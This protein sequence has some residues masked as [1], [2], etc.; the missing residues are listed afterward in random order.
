M[1]SGTIIYVAGNAPEGWTEDDEAHIRSFESKADLIEIIT[2]ET[3]HFDI[4]DA[5]RDLI[6]RG[7][8]QIICKMAVFGESGG[9]EFTGKHL[10]L[11]G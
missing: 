10:K 11:C 5:W 6:S 3:G 9:I 8:A 7:M 4:P 1:K 2:T